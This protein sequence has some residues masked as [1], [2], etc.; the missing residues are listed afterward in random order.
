MK[1]TESRSVI[2]SLLDSA[3]IEQTVHSVEPIREGVTN[4]TSLVVLQDDTRYILREYDWP[5][6]TNDDMQRAVK[7]RYLHDL[8]LK[9]DVP[10]PSILAQYDDESAS[11]LLMEYRPGKLLGNVDDALPDEQRAEAWTAVGAALRKVHSIRLPDGCSGVIVGERVQPFDEGSWGDF[12]YHQAVRH[13]ENL[14]KRDLG[15]RFD[16]ASMMRVLKL[17]IPVLNER[18]LVLLHNDPHPWNALVHEVAGH[19]R[20]SAWLDWEYAWTGDP[21]W[22]LARLDLFR[23]KPIGPTPAAF[24]EGYGNAPKDP[25]QTIYE[26]SI[27]LWMADQYLDGEVDEERVLMPT[28]KAAM[29]YLG[30]IDEAVERIGNELERADRLP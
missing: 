25:E 28:Y 13:A 5:Y 3:G 14:L 26:L 6:A 11:A 23:L 2:V 18:P 19:W 29:Q 20:C 4:R 15:L 30:R 1:H 17:A 24:Y 10:V 9:H 8:L 16:L 27:Y 7:E 22:D 21:T 12:H